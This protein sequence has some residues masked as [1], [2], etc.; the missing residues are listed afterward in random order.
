MHILSISGLSLQFDEKVVLDD[1]NLQVAE[2]DIIALLG[3]SGAGKSSLLNSIAQLIKPSDGQVSLFDQIF[4]YPQSNLTKNLAT[5]K[6]KLGMVFQDAALWPHLTVL[7][8]LITAPIKVLKQ[9]KTIVTDK[10]KKLLNQFGLIDLLLSYPHQLSG[11]QCQRIA[12]LRTLMM[13]PKIMLL[14]EPTSALDPKTMQL[15][16]STLTELSQQGI[17][18]ILTTHDIQFAKQI[19]NRVLY[20]DDSKILDD[21]SVTNHT[22]LPNNP[23]FKAFLI[24]EE[25]MSHEDKKLA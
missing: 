16:A 13:D 18:I 23:A 7:D 21:Q 12:I 14:D 15:I 3:P 24:H 6:G 4:T 1:I 17:T 9:E 11:G 8:N 22:I 20:L 10:A 2:G 19:A 5:L 25:I